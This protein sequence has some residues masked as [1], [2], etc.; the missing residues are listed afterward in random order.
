MQNKHHAELKFQ[1]ILPDPGR[2]GGGPTAKGVVQLENIVA[3]EEAESRPELFQS[4]SGMKLEQAL[5]LVKRN[6]KVRDAR[7]IRPGR[8]GVSDRRSQ[9][10]S[11]AN[12]EAQGAGHDPPDFPAERRRRHPEEGS[13]RSASARPACWPVPRWRQW[14]SPVPEG[15]SHTVPK[16]RRRGSRADS[17]RTDSRSRLSSRAP[18]SSS[19]RSGRRSP[20]ADTFPGS[21]AF[22]PILLRSEAAGRILQ[23]LPFSDRVPIL[24]CWFLSDSTPRCPV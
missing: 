15:R 11:K 22:P 2:A 3:A 24:R 8:S 7:S 20:R 1:N 21:G 14:R 6:R 23:Y 18:R 5:L 13:P 16:R 17:A 10:G 9:A 4:V 12:S 19:C